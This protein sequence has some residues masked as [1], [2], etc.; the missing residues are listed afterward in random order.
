MADDLPNF[1][2]VQD[3]FNRSTEHLHQPANC[4]H[5]GAMELA[6]LRNLPNVG[7]ALDI[8]QEL[9]AIRAEMREQNTALRA[10]MRAQNAQIT[11]QNAQITT[12]LQELRKLASARDFNARDFNV[13]ARLQNSGVRDDTQELVVLR[14]VSTNPVNAANLNEA[15]PHFP[16]NVRQMN[17]VAYG[18]EQ[19]RKGQELTY[20]QKKAIKA[21]GVVFDLDL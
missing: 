1:D 2:N 20:L 6:K 7:N 13:Y 9:R 21:I 12:E 18:I 5:A 16:E 8:M 19:A 17:D 14:P 4:Q 15:I 11:A 10:D 3:F